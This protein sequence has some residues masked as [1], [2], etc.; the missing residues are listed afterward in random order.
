[1]LSIAQDDNYSK[2]LGTCPLHLP[3]ICGMTSEQPLP[4]LILRQQ[5]VRWRLFVC[6]VIPKATDGMHRKRKPFNG[7]TG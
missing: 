7:P 1:M 6:Q 4:D 3:S 5:V 2:L